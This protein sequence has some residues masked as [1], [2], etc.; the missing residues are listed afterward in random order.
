MAYLKNLKAALSK[1]ILEDSDTL[2]IKGGRRKV[3]YKR[4]RA[5]R[6]M[7]NLIARGETPTMHEHNG[8]YCIDW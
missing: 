3:F 7:A 2:E 8:T 6:K 5:L 1:N 4:R